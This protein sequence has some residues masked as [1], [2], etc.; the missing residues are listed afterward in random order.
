MN[1]HGSYYAV[2]CLTETRKTDY[3]CS[4]GSNEL[5]LQ[6][7]YCT[8]QRPSLLFYTLER[9]Q[10]CLHWRETTLQL[11]SGKIIRLYDSDTTAWAGALERGVGDQGRGRHK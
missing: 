3:R 8:K 6:H 2:S 4:I 7:I 9:G 1:T 5:E 11:A 10:V